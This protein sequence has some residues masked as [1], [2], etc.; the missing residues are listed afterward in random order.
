MLSAVSTRVVVVAALRISAL[1]DSF[2]ATNSPA[3]I[4]PRGPLQM[5][6]AQ[7]VRVA[8]IGLTAYHMPIEVSVLLDRAG[9]ARKQ[10]YD[11]KNQERVSDA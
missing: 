1:A 4:S 7:A 3:K 2:T 6:W 5:D 8:I 11:K 10:S 9:T